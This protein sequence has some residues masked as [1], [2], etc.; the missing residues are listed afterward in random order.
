MKSRSHFSALSVI[1]LISLCSS[2][3][4]SVK[5]CETVTMAFE[6]GNSSGAEKRS[7][8]HHV[9]LYV[10]R[11]VCQHILSIDF[12]F[13]DPLGSKGCQCQCSGS[14]ARAKP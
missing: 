1:S 3:R 4:G 14:K 5:L 12:M 7:F 11:V 13:Y 8:S 6:Q 2:E 9:C 10:C